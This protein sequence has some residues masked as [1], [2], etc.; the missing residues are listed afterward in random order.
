M[1]DLITVTGKAR[2]I[3]GNQPDTAV[4]EVF[5]PDDVV[6]IAL[7]PIV[8]DLN[9][10]YGSASGMKEKAFTAVANQQLYTIAD[11]IGS[12]VSE[13]VEVIRSSAR[14]PD[15]LPSADVDPRTGLP[16]SRASI[17]QGYQDDAMEVIVGQWRARH[18][19]KF[20]WE[21]VNGVSLRLMPVPAGAEDVIVQYVSTG[22]SITTLPASTETALIY[23]ACVAI[24]NGQINRVNSDR[25]TADTFG[26]AKDDRIRSMVQQRDYYQGQYDREVS[27]M[28]N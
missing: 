19:D 18:A 21:I 27:K 26:Q 2:K 20:A 1:P 25:A 23:A 11:V 15:A 7:A 6:D 24:L 13:I 14:C 10:L 9:K 8:R 3:I 12:D 17:P 16:I 22:A 4:G 5:I 28:P